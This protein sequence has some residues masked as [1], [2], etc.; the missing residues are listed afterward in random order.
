MAQ[1]RHPFAEMDKLRVAKGYTVQDFTKSLA[2]NVS[3]Y[4][5][6]AE[7]GTVLDK[8]MVRAK[9][10]RQKQPSEPILP[11]KPGPLGKESPDVELILEAEVD[12]GEL[13]SE[14][15]RSER[16]GLSARQSAYLARKEEN[17]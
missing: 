11:Y 13:L 16:L 3:T 1:P 5:S 2:L 9:K 10:L 6:W 14:Q 12:L 15:E 7:V 4:Y 17:E 8:H